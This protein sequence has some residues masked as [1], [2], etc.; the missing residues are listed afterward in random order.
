VIA[1]A[2]VNSVTRMQLAEGTDADSRFR[3]GLESRALR[4]Q[5]QALRKQ[6][7]EA[8]FDAISGQFD[9]QIRETPV[10][11]G[12]LCASGASHDSMSTITSMV[13]KNHGVHGGS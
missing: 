12:A 13:R 5:A 6:R 11:A 4:T 7:S 2:A 8:M 9:P 3:L 10:R 1:N